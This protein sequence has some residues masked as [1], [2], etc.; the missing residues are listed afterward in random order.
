M[1]GS[2]VGFLRKGRTQ[3]PKVNVSP[4]V[5]TP[6][7]P[8][9]PPCHPRS[10]PHGQVLPLRNQTLVDGA[11]QQGDAALADLVSEGLTGDAN[12]TSKGGALNIQVQVIS[13]LWAGK[14][15]AS[16]HKRTAATPKRVA[17]AG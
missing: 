6:P 17:V 11:G 3:Q 13:R 14:N 1:S 7:R 5:G 16:S 8:N 12:G 10:T 2:G 15:M 4:R 9:D